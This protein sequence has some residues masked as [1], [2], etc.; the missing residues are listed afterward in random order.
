MRA[1][2]GMAEHENKVRGDGQAAGDRRVLE[3]LLERQLPSLRAFVRLRA[4]RDVRARESSADIVQSVCREI[5]Q[6]L[7]RFEYRDEA[8]FRSWLFDTALHKIIDRHRYHHAAKRDAAREMPIGAGCEAGDAQ[9][10]AC[11]TRIASPSRGAIARVEAAFDALPDDY[12]RVITL[13]RIVGLSHG[14]IAREMGRS[15]DAVRNLLARALA[16]LGGVLARAGG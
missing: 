3:E 14:E 2:G 10:L 16:R 4:G 15:E 8:A 9:I 11:Y 5:L 12:R 13:A 1:K 7:G 6:D